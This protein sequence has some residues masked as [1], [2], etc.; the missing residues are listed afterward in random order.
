MKKIYCIKHG[1]F[2]NP[3]IS[4][5]FDKTLVLSI[6]ITNHI[7][8]ELLDV[9]IEHL[10]GRYQHLLDQSPNQ[11]EETTS[12]NQC[13]NECDVTKGN[14]I[15]ESKFQNPELNKNTPPLY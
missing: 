12:N 10:Q 4:Y 13:S 3:K 7:D 5:I 15:I 2:K 8:S 14:E 1:K 11:P 6:I 9:E